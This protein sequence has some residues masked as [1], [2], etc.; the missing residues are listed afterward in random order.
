M[1]KSFGVAF[2]DMKPRDEP[3]RP[4]VPKVDGMFLG[5]EIR[6]ENVLNLVK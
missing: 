1:I 3:A 2:T 5:N 6:K 4:H